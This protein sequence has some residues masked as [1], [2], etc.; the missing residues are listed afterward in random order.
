MVNEFFLMTNV[1]IIAVSVEDA[2]GSDW[3]VDEPVGEVVRNIGRIDGVLKLAIVCSDDIRKVGNA[4][5]LAFN[6][7][8]VI[9]FVVA[10]A[11]GRDRCFNDLS[12]K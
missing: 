3:S 8:D 4:F 11:M 1:L 2:C 10:C 6:A 12:L 5:R 9:V 7:Q